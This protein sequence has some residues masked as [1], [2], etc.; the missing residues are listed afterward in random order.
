MFDGVQFHHC[1][2]LRRLDEKFKFHQEYGQQLKTGLLTVSSTLLLMDTVIR[3]I[4]VTQCKRSYDFR[5][6]KVPEVKY[7]FM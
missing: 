5:I 1:L 7:F 4:S 6:F 3:L 2:L